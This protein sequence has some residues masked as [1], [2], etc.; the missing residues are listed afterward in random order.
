[1]NTMRN[2]SFYNSFNMEHPN[3]M[4]YKKQLHI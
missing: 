2:M 1:M 4:P 3:Q